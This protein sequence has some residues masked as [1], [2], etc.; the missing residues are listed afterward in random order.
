MAKITAAKQKP[1]AFSQK[2][3]PFA[4]AEFFFQMG[5]KVQKISQYQVENKGKNFYT[6][7][8]PWVAVESF[9]E[10]FTNV[11]ENPQSFFEETRRFWQDYFKVYQEVAL[12]TWAQNGNY[13]VID[14]T[15]KDKRFQKEPWQKNPYYFYLQQTYLLW[16]RWATNIADDVKITDKHKA[17]KVQFYV[18]QWIDALSP[19]NNPLTNPD[20]FKKAFE[21]QGKSLVKGFQN[22]LQDL[23][24]GRGS[25]KIKMADRDA[26]QVGKNIASSRGKVVFQNDLI[27]LLQYESLTEKVF[28]F[29]ILL[30][31]PCINKFY[32]FDLRESNSFIRWLLQQGFTVFVISWVNPDQRLAHKTFENYVLEGVKGAIDAILKITGELYVN[33]LGYCIGGNFLATLS[34]YLSDEPKNPLRTTS[35]LATLF[36]F[37]NAG[38]L[39]VFIDEKQLKDIEER[40]RKQGFLDGET[41]ARTFNLLRANDLIWSFVVNNYYLGED[42]QAFDLLYWN[43]DSTNL[44]ASM[45]TY[46]L[47]NMFF[48]N[49]LLKPGGIKIGNKLLDLSQV[50]TPS[51]IL[52]TREDHIAPWWCGYK[53]MHVLSGPKKFVLGGSGHVAGIFNH[54]QSH[55]YGFWT[56]SHLPPTDAD[57]ISTASHQ[58]GSWWNEW[59]SWIKEYNQEYIDAR[60]CGSE[61]FPP[62]EDAPG[63]FVSQ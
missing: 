61:Q 45:Y 1:E 29:P 59:L 37:E 11:T 6:I 17:Q 8:N 62:L 28:R 60:S 3:D 55:K 34:G 13:S 47:R 36:D 23:E 38:D 63:S 16:K 26:F 35:Y 12:S 32:I 25:L 46:Y 22:F 20:V 49:L 10:A 39:L 4:M 27:Q 2:H 21:T 56:N 43:S 33:V 9:A 40:T 5:K 15:L 24:E 7:F 54:P 30:I 19:T 31:P 14:A 48:K 57:W 42:P 51:F 41:L 58:P 52:N 53:G 18:R 44:P 50:K